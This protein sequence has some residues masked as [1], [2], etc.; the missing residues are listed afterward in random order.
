[1]GGDCVKN[2]VDKM[3]WFFY[4]GFY[5]YIGGRCGS[6]NV[7]NCSDRPKVFV[8]HFIANSREVFRLKN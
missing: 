3:M 8:H 4:V 2:L 1:M 5:C 6:K 7:E